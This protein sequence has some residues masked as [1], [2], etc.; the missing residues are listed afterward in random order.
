[1]CDKT[2]SAPEKNQ[3]SNKEKKIF[4]R[5]E[6]AA[7]DEPG[8]YLQL[9][10]RE[11]TLSFHVAEEHQKAVQDTLTAVHDLSSPAAGVVAEPDK[12][13]D[14]SLTETID[15]LSGRPCRRCLI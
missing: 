7:R 5:V 13:P 6:M 14:R 15:A 3:R 8:E 4:A 9:E 12:P 10:S 11:L 2:F 1:L